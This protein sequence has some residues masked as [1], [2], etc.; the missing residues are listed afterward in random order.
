MAKP[1]HK[2]L[3]ESLGRV[4]KSAR[5]GIVRSHDISRRD[6]ERLSKSGWLQQI[7]TGWYLLISPQA[8]QGESTPWFS[9]FWVFIQQYLH[10]RFGEDYC[11]SAE[12]SLDIHTANNIIPQQ[13]VAITKSGGNYT[14]S[15]P[16]Q[17]S[18]V[19]YQDPKKFPASIE[20]KN[21]LQ[22]MPVGLALCR[23][24]KSF[25]QRQPINAKI[26]L[27]TSSI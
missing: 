22:L 3:A 18:I 13:I 26:S 11:L 17:T 23:T 4:E 2:L 25:F 7:I 5:D 15:L 6:R 27:L 8:T 20:M 16:H 9:S 19:V 12:S 1:F 10:E 24:T 14:L 21:K